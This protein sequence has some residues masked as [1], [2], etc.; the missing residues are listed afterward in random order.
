MRL[1]P[2]PAGRPWT[3]ADDAQLL[4]LVDSKMDN[5]SIARK[6]QRTVDAIAKRKSHLQQPAPPPLLDMDV[7]RHPERQFMQHLRAGGWLKAATL[8]SSPKLIERLLN[9]AWIERCGT[10]K[11]LAYRITDKGLAA[12]K[13]PVRT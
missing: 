7:P 13:A 11:D 4:A 1:G 8:P 2:R 10:G 12:K 3:P 9:K 6:M 5:A